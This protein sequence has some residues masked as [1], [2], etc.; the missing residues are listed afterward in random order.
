MKKF[1]AMMLAV[2]MVVGMTACS[3]SNKA[4]TANDG[5]LTM[6]TNAQFPP[7]E[8][9]EGDTITGID[10]DIANAIA[11]KLG[12]TLNVEDMEFDSVI[13]SVKGGKADIGMAGITVTAEREEAVD[14]T[15]SYATA[16]QVIVVAEDNDTI[17]GTNDDLA[18]VDADGNV[19]EGTV[20]AVQRNTTGDL[21]ATWNRYSKHADAIQAVLTGKADC[22]ILDNEPAKVF[23]SETEGLKMLEAE[24]VEEQYA[25][26]MSK[27]NKELYDAVNGALEEL[28]KDGTVKTIVDKY[29]SAE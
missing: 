4:K 8:Y 27:D 18:L 1:I 23:V 21:Y 12:L 16:T 11:E 6:A 28:I 20:I 2:M 29:I 17:A 10:V 3:S 19:L 7:Y 14:F 26:A 24:Y 5:V 13:E 15:T 25:I 22:V 9:Y